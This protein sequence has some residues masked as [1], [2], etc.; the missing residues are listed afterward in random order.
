[1]AGQELQDRS[2]ELERC[3]QVD[4]STHDRM[5]IFGTNSQEFLQTPGQ[6][7]NLEKN[8]LS[9]NISLVRDD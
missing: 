4:I 5:L 6:A 2:R 9:R 7:S 8:L 3:Y 1:L